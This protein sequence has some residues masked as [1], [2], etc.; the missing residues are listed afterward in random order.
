[1]TGG[2]WQ[3]AVGTFAEQAPES[4]GSDAWHTVLQ[5][6]LYLVYLF[7][8]LFLL[9]RIRFFRL[10]GIPESWTYGAFLVKIP[11]ALLLY[12]VYT[13]VYTDRSTADIFKYFDDGKVLADA[14]FSSPADFFSMLSGIGN[15]HPHFNQYYHRMNNWCGIYPSNIY[16]DGH[17]LI[18]FNA[19]LSLVSLH[20][21]HIHALVMCFLSFTGILA[22]YKT[23]LPAF[24]SLRKAFFLLLFLT[25]SL[26]FWTSGV[27]KEGLILFSS[28]LALYLTDK[29][30]RNKITI[31]SVVLL[32]LS[33]IILRYSKFYVF[34]LL[35]PLL[36][37]YGISMRTKT[38][39]ARFIF[40]A[41]IL[42]FAGLGLLA[43]AFNPVYDISEIMARKQQDFLRIAR[44]AGAGSLI[45]TETLEPGFRNMLKGLLPG[46]LTTFFRPACWE[47]ANPLIIVAGIENL[48]IWSI[49]LL[50]LFRAGKPASIPLFLLSVLFVF[51]VFAVTGLISPVTGAIV[52]YKTPALPFLIISLC[53]LWTNRPLPAGR[54]F[55]KQGFNDTKQ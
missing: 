38:H 31:I 46:F 15:D 2:D 43:G 13:M 19:L 39:R 22:I 50:V 48:L 40:P 35:L 49:T 51:S 23:A 45:S 21:Y 53:S 6:F 27:L 14:F 10:E 32:L 30:A 52:K 12:L 9:K 54:L 34:I 16:G 24:P 5:A 28:G 44:E 18:R 47:S 26:L 4:L 55:R 37:A 29:I 11:A 25:P 20:N 36:M 17:I 33:L 1:M 8:I 41:V 42:L 3:Q 7:I